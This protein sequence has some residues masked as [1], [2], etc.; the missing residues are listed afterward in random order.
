MYNL[1]K[2]TCESSRVRVKLFSQDLVQVGK[3]E[4]CKFCYWKIYSLSLRKDVFLRY[5]EYIIGLLP[6]V[7]ISHKQC[8]FA[9]FG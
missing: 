1:V 3:R 9:V 8:L 7:S 6:H 4:L 5:E 2:G